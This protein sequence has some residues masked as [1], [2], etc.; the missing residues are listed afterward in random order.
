MISL[1]CPILHC[2]YILAWNYCLGF[3]MIPGCLSVGR[4][5]V[6]SLHFYQYVSLNPLDPLSSAWRMDRWACWAVLVPAFIHTSEQIGFCSVGVSGFLGTAFLLGVKTLGVHSLAAGLKFTPILFIE[7]EK[8]I[9][10]QVLHEEKAAC[11]N[12]LFLPSS[13]FPLYSAMTKVPS[14]F[15]DMAHITTA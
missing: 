1:I 6:Q 4:E 7:T 13:P 15:P 10:R 11:E 14:P 2:L 8:W 9:Q 3:V 5:R 12:S